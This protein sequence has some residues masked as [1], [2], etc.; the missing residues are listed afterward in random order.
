MIIEN[1]RAQIC[2]I[3]WITTDDAEI[4]NFLGDSYISISGSWNNLGIS[5]AE[6]KES[7]A[8]GEMVQ[9]ELK[10]TISDSSEDN[11]K[12]LKGILSSEI[13]LRIDYTNKESKVIGTDTCPVSLSLE[14]S[15][16]PEKLILSVKR[17]SPEPSKFIQSF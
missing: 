17:S 8:R 14:R 7:Q 15:G 6:F 5:S 12:R 9:Q 16:T 3:W 13:I 1:K 4:D 11:E 2:A 10:A